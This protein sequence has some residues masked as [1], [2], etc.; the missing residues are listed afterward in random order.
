MSGIA[1]RA[2]Y[3][4]VGAMMRSPSSRSPA[5][6]I[7]T[8]LARLR[9]EPAARARVAVLIDGIQS[10]AQAAVHN[11][12]L[13]EVTALTDLLVG[14]QPELVAAVM[15]DEPTPVPREEFDADTRT[16]ASTQNTQSRTST[17]NEKK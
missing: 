1:A 17:I 11:S 10:A 4:I 16:A 14:R 15:G 12:D 5:L 3:L 7:D 9:D 6:E 2:V 8:L 13:G